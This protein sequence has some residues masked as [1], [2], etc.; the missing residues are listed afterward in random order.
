MYLDVLYD[1]ALL[2]VVGEIDHSNYYASMPM[3]DLSQPGVINESG[4]FSGSIRPLGS[5]V[6]PLYSIP[7]RAIAPGTALIAGDE[8]DCKPMTDI[9]VYGED[10]MIPEK[11]VDFG[12]STL[13]IGTG[14]KSAANRSDLIAQ[15][16]DACFRVTKPVAAIESDWAEDLEWVA[17]NNQ[18]HVAVGD[19]V[20]S[21]SM[22]LLS[23]RGIAKVVDQVFQVLWLPMSEDATVTSST[24]SVDVRLLSS[25]SGALNGLPVESTVS[26]RAEPIEE[27][28]ANES[29][30]SLDEVFAQLGALEAGIL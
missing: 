17:N 24:E 7:I 20:S 1:S 29:L 6:L 21:Y 23:E 15:A 22:G 4:A 8:A 10:I 3:G 27:D 2:E 30:E 11:L 9:G 14:G 25:S 5:G 28:S 18:S 12:E 13:R 16:G 19:Y 26:D